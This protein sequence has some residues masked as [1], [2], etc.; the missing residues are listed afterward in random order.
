MSV[1][2]KLGGA[3]NAEP[4]TGLELFFYYISGGD[5]SKHREL[6]SGLLRL[7]GTIPLHVLPCYSLVLNCT[8]LNV[9]FAVG[10]VQVFIRYRR[11]VEIHSVCPCTAALDILASG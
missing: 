11:R 3:F 4:L 5:T 6:V 9:V 8:W 2:K 1:T 7:H 10:W